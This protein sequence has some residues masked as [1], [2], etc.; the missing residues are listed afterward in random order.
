MTSNVTHPGDVPLLAGERWYVPTSESWSPV[1]NPSRG[2]QIARVPQ[3]G[4]A[5]VGVAVQA[6]TRAFSTW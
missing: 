1:F 6:A 2:E 5:E 4:A 3:C